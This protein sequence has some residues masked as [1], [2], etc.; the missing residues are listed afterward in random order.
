MS[1][2]ASALTGP[3]GSGFLLQ[4]R[5]YL[6]PIGAISVIFVMLIPLPAAGLDL[7]LAISM[8]ASIIVFLSS[9]QIRRA[10]GLHCHCHHFRVI[11]GRGG[12]PYCVSR[13]LGADGVTGPAPVRASAP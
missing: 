3:S 6:L 11:N 9:V 10:V 7:L 12:R 1:T 4:L 2:A 8:A 13:V 5:D